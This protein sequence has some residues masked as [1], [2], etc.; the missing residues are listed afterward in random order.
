MMSTMAPTICVIT[1]SRADFGF[2]APVMK[3]IAGHPRL[4]LQTI[5]TGTHLCP[6][7]GATRQA[8]VEAGVEIDA[9][10][11]MVLASD[12]AIAIG[13]A[14]G[15]GTIGFADALARLSPDLVMVLGDRYEVLAAVSAALLA[16]IPVAHLAGGDI[17][18]GAVD[19]QIRHAVTKMAH[20]HF[21]TNEAAA[22]R[23]RQMGEDPRRVI[24]A[25]S[26]GLDAI[27]G[28]ERRSPGAVFEAI[29]FAPRERNALVVFHPVTL[30]HVPSLT[31]LEALLEALE[32]QVGRLGMVVCAA[33]AD[34]EGASI[35]QRL[36]RFAQAHA[37]EHV[38]F[39]P[40]FDHA[41]YVDFL[42]AVDVLLGNS[43]SALYEAP[44]LGTAAVNIGERQRGRLRASS[45]LDVAPDPAAIAERIDDALALDLRGVTNPYGDGRATERIVDALLAIDDYS[46][47]IHKRFEVR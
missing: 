23:I 10:V 31:Q 20:L 21:P 37:G 38:M 1:G 7:F 9:Q 2:L 27:L 4:T 39:V 35:N 13:K 24:C 43:S 8:I 41:T 46:A 44:S 17:T 36:Q 18:Q 34:R 12:G 26:T 11:D 25:G 32:R 42:A 22:A 47:L 3:A 16:R 28:R 45:V 6:G 19:E 5:A 33:N 14:V 15:L 29:G 30:G 40:S